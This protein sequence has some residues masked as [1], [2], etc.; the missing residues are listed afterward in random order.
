VKLTAAAGGG[1]AIAVSIPGWVSPGQDSAGASFTPNLL[2]RID[3]DGTI[4][5]VA[6]R[7][8]MGQGV[9]TSL[10]MLVAEELEVELEDVRLEQADLDDGFEEYGGQYVGGS[11][12]VRT[13]WVP[14]RQ[15]GAAAREMLV[16]AAAARWGVDSETC[17]ARAAR[18][19]HPE[20]GRSLGYGELAVEASE[21]SLPEDPPL[22]A[23]AD[24]RLI[25]TEVPQVDAAGIT[26]GSVPFG[27]D[28]ELPG[29]LHAAI[30]HSP[31]LGGGV[32]AV[33]ASRASSLPGVRVIEID[34]RRMPDFPPNNPKP[35]NG[36]AVLADSTWAAFQARNRLS[37]EWEPPA[38]AAS[39]EST[40]RFW[41]RCREQ[42][43]EPPERIIREDG[44]LDGA[45]RAATRR[46]DAVYRVPFLA[47][48]PMEPMNAAA[49][50]EGD[51]CEVWVPTQN[52]AGAR[53]IAAIVSGL[54]EA[55]ITVHPLRMGGA[56]GR[57][58]YSDFVA[59]AVYL[60]REAGRPV[61]VVWTREDDIR[62]G[63]YRPAGYHAM[64]GGLDSTG[65]LVAW[66]HHL[67]NASRY[68]A[69][70]R[71]A[72]A[73]AGEAYP[74]DLPAE[75][76]PNFRLSYTSVNSVIP[77]GQWRAI[78]YSANVFVVES[79]IDELAHAADSD[80]FRFRL[81]LL[82]EPREVPFYSRTYDSGRLRSVL[83]IAADRAGWG[84]PLT[85]GRAQGIAASYANGAFVA[86]V[87]EVSVE[88][89][90]S[91]R[92]HRVTSAVDIGTVVNPS[93][94]R[95]QEEGSVAMGLSATVGEQ[96][97]VTDG[98][99]D[100]SNFHDYPVLRIDRM[101]EVDVHFVSSS[102]PPEGIGEGALPPLAPAITNAV[103]AA[104]GQRIR[105]LPIRMQSE[106]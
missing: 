94:A 76:V 59:Q 70:G 16:A 73:G 14:L 35:P 8:E 39:A 102:R 43:A 83:E 10:P 47:H 78:A 9:R 24:F 68:R 100:Q 103:F 89:D 31:I 3:A 30:A 105:E 67:V 6:P 99:V 54:P 51:R 42:A 69:L 61:Q 66:S 15:A 11:N 72:E 20:S 90:G 22:K 21:L 84:D 53:E 19:H 7:P 1:L 13:S 101:P 18:V 91:L 86:H 106:D 87:A 40:E 26:T 97:T 58:Y 48:A 12:S 29:M 46:L 62:Q 93:G 17:E 60:A 50:V 37:I 25:G 4:T 56:F 2:L 81:R 32:A 5:L 36:V 23:P 79:F 65:E 57:R 71:E 75:F 34:A 92:I 45:L 52:P 63:F 85:D 96:I 95:A 98:R 38:E 88:S 41:R 27:L 77:R 104:T 74:F 64:R 44:Q 55:N 49:L 80:P 28:L 33:D 82:G